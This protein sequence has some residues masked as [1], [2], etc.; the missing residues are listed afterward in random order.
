MIVEDEMLPVTE[1]ELKASRS[2]PSNT[3]G[4]G[5]TTKN[6]SCPFLTNL[7]R[8]IRLQ[9]YSHVLGADADVIHAK[10]SAKGLLYRRCPLDAP[11][12]DPCPGRHSKAQYNFMEGDADE[13]FIVYEGSRH[14]PQDRQ[15]C[16]FGSAYEVPDLGIGRDRAVVLTCKT[17][18]EEITPSLYRGMV[19]SMCDPLVLLRLKDH[20]PSIWE[21]ERIRHI[22]FSDVKYAPSSDGSGPY[23]PNVGNVPD[24]D[25]D[26]I[27]LRFWKILA[28]LRLES[29]KIWLM[30][31]S[32]FRDGPPEVTAEWAQ[33]MLE[34]RGVK[35]VELQ[36]KWKQHLSGMVN[37][38]AA[39]RLHALEDQ[40]KAVW[41]SQ[42]EGV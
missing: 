2:K 18:F 28:D 7:P 5:R 16:P 19:W 35:S 38:Q 40:I 30:Y 22:H 41:L 20:I 15:W 17:V 1:H 24:Y 14:I 36:I 12:I 39:Q 13:P 34:I 42:S 6:A 37:H 3:P 9:I 27:W 10:P 26:G 29:L 23:R 4:Q 21:F 33:N 31:H 11:D 32:D 8:E 25:E